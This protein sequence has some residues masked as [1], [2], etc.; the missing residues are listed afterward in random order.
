MPFNI[1]AFHLRQLIII[2]FEHE[3]PNK[4][5]IKSFKSEKDFLEFWN[6]YKHDL[7]LDKCICNKYGIK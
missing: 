6:N 4:D 3:D 2:R 1:I 7:D 5:Y